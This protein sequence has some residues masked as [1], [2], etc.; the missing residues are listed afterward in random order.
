MDTEIKIITLDEHGNYH[1][2]TPGFSKDNE[3]PIETDENETEVQESQVVKAQA[4]PQPTDGSFYAFPSDGKSWAK[5]ILS[6]LSLLLFIYMFYVPDTWLHTTIKTIKGMFT[7]VTISKSTKFGYAFGL[8]LV[9]FF[10][11]STM[12]WGVGPDDGYP[13]AMAMSSILWVLFFLI[14]IIL[15]A[16]GKKATTPFMKF[17]NPFRIIPF[18]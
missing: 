8:F 16:V 17:E 14:K 5:A 4:Q 9:Q 12:L 10:T 2:R 18:N 1:V 11:I 15:S 13:M 3:K 7:N 6:V